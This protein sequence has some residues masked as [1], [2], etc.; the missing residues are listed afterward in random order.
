VHLWFQH[1]GASAPSQ[2]DAFLYGS[3]H[4]LFSPW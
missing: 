2:L 3:Q 1:H 4:L